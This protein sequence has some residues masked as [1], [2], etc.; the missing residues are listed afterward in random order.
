MKRVLRSAMRLLR[1]QADVAD[2]LSPHAVVGA[3][4]LGERLGAATDWLGARV[5]KALAYL[6]LADHGLQFGVEQLHDLRRRAAR[7]ED[8]EPCAH[9]P[10]ANARFR[11]CGNVGE[12]RQAM[13]CAR[14][15]RS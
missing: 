9:L 11:R 12:H 15:E 5:V 4:A 7:R 10:A 6:R 8:A 1:L 13:A 3:I 14:R 2:E